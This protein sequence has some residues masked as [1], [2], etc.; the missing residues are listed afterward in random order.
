MPMGSQKMLAFVDGAPEQ[1]RSPRYRLLLIARLVTTS[2]E[3]IV[4]LR[5]LS[6]TGAMIEGPRIP[7]PGT[8]ILL[9]RGALE[10]FGTIVWARDMQAGVEFDDPLT[11]TMLWM[12]VNAP[13]HIREEEPT[14]P[15]PPRAA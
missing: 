7:P 14:A 4:K 5:D 12:Q 9:Q 2:Y 8:D 15:P 10:V 3:R 13:R 6:T 11:E 1:R